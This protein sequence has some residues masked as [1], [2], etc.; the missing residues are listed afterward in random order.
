MFF[1]FCYK[2]FFKVVNKCWSE[3]VITRCYKLGVGQLWYQ[4]CYVTEGQ[5]VVPVKEVDVREAVLVKERVDVKQEADEERKKE[6][7]TIGT[8]FHV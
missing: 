2:F 6:D 3:L 5:V 7:P 4:V 1:I 8:Y